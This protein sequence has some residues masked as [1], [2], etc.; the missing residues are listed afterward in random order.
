ML[1]LVE[2]QYILLLKNVFPQ[3]VVGDIRYKRG[4]HEA[5]LNQP[6]ASMC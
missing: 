1:V 5:K 4:N 6:P 3:G 2:E